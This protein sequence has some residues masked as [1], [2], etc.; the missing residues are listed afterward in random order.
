MNANP[1]ATYTSPNGLAYRVTGIQKVEGSE[2]WID[3]V[4][5]Y[6]W[7][8]SICFLNSDKRLTLEYDYSEK[9]IKKFNT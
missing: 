6:H 8:I 7:L 3:G 1:F 2:R 5:R 9:V 4:L